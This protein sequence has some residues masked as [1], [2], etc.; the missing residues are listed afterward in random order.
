MSLKPS[1]LLQTKPNNGMMAM[2]DGNPFPFGY[3]HIFRVSAHFALPAQPIAI[4]LSD[5]LHDPIEDKRKAQLPNC[6]LILRSE[7]EQ[8]EP[9]EENEQ[10]DACNVCL[11]TKVSLKSEKSMVTRIPTSNTHLKAKWRFAVKEVAYMMLDMN[12]PYVL[13]PPLF[14]HKCGEI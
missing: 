9:H 8:A 11:M 14:A 13:D 12:A 2:G 10:E 6:N 4:R 7:Q 1:N 5:S 3:A